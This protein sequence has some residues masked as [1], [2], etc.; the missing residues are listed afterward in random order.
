[1]FKDTL[2]TMSQSDILDNSRFILASIDALYLLSEVNVHMEL[3]IVVSSA[4]KMKSNLEL[5]LSISFMYIM[6]RRGP[7]IEP[8]GTT[9][10]SGR[11]FDLMPSIS[12]YCVLLVK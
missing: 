8:C 7:K 4:Y 3:I 1:M 11:E 5:T 6:K 9:V 2:L 12:M 10:S